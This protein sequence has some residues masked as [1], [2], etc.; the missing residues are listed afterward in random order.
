MDR[1]G[2][3]ARKGFDFLKSRAKETVEVTKLSS[4]I[5]ELEDR[6]DQ[7]LLDIGHRVMAMYDGPV[8]DKEALRDRVEEV[9]SLNAELQAAKDNI[10][11]GF[12]LRL[13]SNAKLLDHVAMIGF[14]RLPL[15]WLARYPHEV[16]AVSVEAV[17]DAWQRRIRPEQLVTV[18]VGGDGDRST[19]TAPAAGGTDPQ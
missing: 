19:P 12:G 11:N 6:R 13:D 16:A 5:R 10:V 17:R 15:D 14:Y 8:F 3:S 4:N 7:C 1:F 2:E 18:I 9:R